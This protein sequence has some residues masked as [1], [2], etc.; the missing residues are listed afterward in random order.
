MASIGFVESLLG[1]LPIDVKR[2]LTEVFRYV[3]PNGRLGPAS[4]QTK[5]ESLQSYYLLSTT[6]ATT[7]VEFSVLHGLGRIPYVA[8]P[9]LALDSSGT[10]L[11]DLRVSRPADAQRVYFTDRVSTNVPFFLLVE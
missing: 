6:A 2:A 3:L 10:I 7:G 11:P 5:S 9:V 4:H 1:A 8:V